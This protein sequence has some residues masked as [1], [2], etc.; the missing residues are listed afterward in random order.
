MLSR[1]HVALAVVVAAW[2]SWLPYARADEL[3]VVDRAGLVRAVRS[4]KGEGTIVV[5]LSPEAARTTPE[6]VLLNIDGTTTERRAPVDSQGRCVVRQAAATTWQVDVPS[7]GRYKV[8]IDA[9]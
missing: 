5:Q 3:R 6:C 8:Q 2:S 7:T 4:I 1:N 9:K